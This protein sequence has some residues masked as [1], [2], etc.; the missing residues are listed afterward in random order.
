MILKTTVALTRD[1][2]VDRKDYL[3]MV[4]LAVATWLACFYPPLAKA[5][6]RHNQFIVSNI[7]QVG[8]NTNLCTAR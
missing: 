2:Q 5:K 8:G 3:G 4:D 6:A 7:E 1:S